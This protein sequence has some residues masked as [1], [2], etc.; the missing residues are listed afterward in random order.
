MLCGFVVFLHYYVAT[1]APKHK[2]KYRFWPKKAILCP[3]RHPV[4]NELD[5]MPKKLNLPP[6]PLKAGQGA[7]GKCH[8]EESRVKR[9]DVAVS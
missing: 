1:K 4:N 8:C 7:I 5:A 3:K 6:V 9:D 2:D